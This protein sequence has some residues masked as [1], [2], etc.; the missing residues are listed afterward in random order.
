MDSQS[1]AAVSRDKIV[2]AFF[3]ACIEGNLWAVKCF[4]QSLGVT[5]K[6]A[7]GLYKKNVYVYT[8]IEWTSLKGHVEVLRYLRE[9]MGLTTDD[10]RA[11]TNFALRLA[12]PRGHVKVLKYL[13]DGF[14]L[15]TEDARADNNFALRLA[16]RNGHSAIV[17]CLVTKFGLTAKDARTNYNYALRKAC[18]HGHHE[19]V[20]S[21]LKTGL[22]TRADAEAHLSACRNC[23][24]EIVLCL[25]SFAAADFKNALKRDPALK[26]R[27]D[28]FDDAM[29]RTGAIIDEYNKYKCW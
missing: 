16:A 3:D 25:N 20:K 1:D 10:A 13:F 7:R 27:F 6:D 29:M 17:K 11:N 5:A 4:H 8:A 12:S 14:R 23:K 24:P 19:V 22:L 21:M 18:K 2:K 28:E 26:R 15:T 9:E